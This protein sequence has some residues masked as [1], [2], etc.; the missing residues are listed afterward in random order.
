M[1]GVFININGNNNE[2]KIGKNVYVNR[3]LNC[4]IFKGGI[5]ALSD[6]CK[7]VIG[8]NCFFNGGNI[9]LL[10]GEMNTHIDIGNDCLFASDITLATSDNH[11]IFNKETKKRLNYAGNIVIG[12]HCWIC[13]DVKILN[14]SYIGDEC[15]IAT[16]ALVVSFPKKLFSF[17]YKKPPNNCIIGGIPARILKKNIV[18]HREIKE[19]LE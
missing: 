8:D 12:K 2:I 5:G 17:F 19:F 4:I 11:S 3:T 9:S 1:G 7:I 15:V 16:K 13:D 6:K 10:C 14:H 18:W